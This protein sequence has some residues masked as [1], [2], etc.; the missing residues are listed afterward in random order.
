MF[1]FTSNVRGKIGG[2]HKVR[3]QV[4]G[5]GGRSK[6]YR[7]VQ[8]GRGGGLQHRVRTHLDYLFLFSLSEKI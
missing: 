1:M 6:A 2:I 7:C 4:G 8:G 5:R 3:T